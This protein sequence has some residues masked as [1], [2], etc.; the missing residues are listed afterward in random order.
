MIQRP[1]GV[2]TFQFVTLAALR[3]TQLS[4]GCRPKVDGEHK[5]TVLA[6]IEV[7]QGKVRQVFA[8]PEASGE[9]TA[10][11]ESVTQDGSAPVH[12]I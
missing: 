12:T 4:R 10:I 8:K 7:A 5:V 1:P 6:Q 9:P 3:A 2:G 11:I